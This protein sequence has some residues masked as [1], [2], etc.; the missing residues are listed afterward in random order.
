MTVLLFASSAVTVILNDVPEVAADGA[1]TVKWVAGPAVLE[2]VPM[3][4][5]WSPPAAM[6]AAPVRVLTWTGV[7]LFVVEPL[8]NSPSPL[9]PQAQ[10]VPSLFSARL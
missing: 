2:V 6:P 8:P 9:Y 4:R 1:E 3:A 5:L 10:T 7:L